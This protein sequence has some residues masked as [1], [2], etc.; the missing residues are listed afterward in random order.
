MPLDP[1]TL[2]RRS[3]NCFGDRDCT[4]PGEVCQ[5]DFDNRDDPTQPYDGTLKQA[6]YNGVSSNVVDFLTNKE[7]GLEQFYEVI[8]Q[9]T[10]F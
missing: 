2:P 4:G 7:R 8:R 5:I 1:S 6:D 9:G 3:S 10:K